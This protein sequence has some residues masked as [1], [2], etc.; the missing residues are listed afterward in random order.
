MSHAVWVQVAKT[1]VQFAPS[2]FRPGK[3]VFSLAW[4]GVLCVGTQT[5]KRCGTAE[6]RPEVGGDI[7]PNESPSGQ[8][9]TQSGQFIQKWAH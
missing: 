5:Q 1:V 4:L 6:K 3:G 9:E 2:K 8:N 7:Q